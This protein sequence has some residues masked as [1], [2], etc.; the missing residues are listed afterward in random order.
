MNSKRGAA[1]RLAG[2]MVNFN[3]PSAAPPEV[4]DDGPVLAQN[5]IAEAMFELAAL[6]TGDDGDQALGDNAEEA[7]YPSQHDHPGWPILPSYAP[8]Q[9][10]QQ[11]WCCE[12]ALKAVSANTRG[13]NMYL[14][15]FNFVFIFIL[16]FISLSLYLHLYLFIFV[17]IS[18]SSSLYLHDYLFMIIF[19]S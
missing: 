7:P 14:F 11:A 18:L 4:A 10:I 1:I 3:A 12:P 9:Q 5:S 15:V 16:F 13:G 8:P 19:L 2:G 17:C 6:V